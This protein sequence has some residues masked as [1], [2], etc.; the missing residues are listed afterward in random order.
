MTS[1]DFEEHTVQILSPVLAKQHEQDARATFVCLAGPQAG[2][3]L[4]LRI[5]VNNLGRAV[6]NQIVINSPGV[7]RH[8]ARA[9]VAAGHCTL[10]DLGST[11]GTL[12]Q[13][14]LISGPVALHDG[15]RIGLGAETVLQFRLEDRLERRMRDHLYELATRDPLTHAH[16]RRFFDERLDSE[17][18]WAQR[19]S[20]S[21]AVL[22]LDLDHFKRVNDNHGHPAGDA[23][24]EQFASRIKPALR[25]EDLF[26]RVGGEEFAVLCRATGIPDAMALAERL[27]QDVAARPFQWQGQDLPLTVSIG[28]AATDEG[29]LESIPDLLARADERLYASKAAGRNSVQGPKQAESTS[30]ARRETHVEESSPRSR[31]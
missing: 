2:R 19:H 24:L 29:G 16:N 30:R 5:G 14:S 9:T 12:V 20:R 8:H 10:Q 25:K 31:S 21:C 13:D 4:T 11:N 7:S 1:D 26:A 28:V 15:D 22:W 18:P 23:I 3:V 27:R 6:D 17:W